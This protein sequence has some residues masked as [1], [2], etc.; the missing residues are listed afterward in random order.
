MNSMLSH[1]A[2]AIKPSPTLMVSALAKKMKSEG[3]DVINFGV[4]EPD[5]NTPDY[6]KNAAKKALDDNFT[7]YT[8]SAGIPELRE[9]IVEKFLK[10]NN[11]KYSI[12]EILVSPGAKASIIHILLAICD[13]RDE[14]LIPSPYW[15]SYTSQVEMVD[16]HP[17]LLP[18]NMSTNFKITAHQLED[19]LSSLSSPKA[20]I[21]NSPNNPTGTVYN[22]QE[23]KEIA[24]VCLKHN[25]LILSDEIYEKLTYDGEEHHSIA[26]V[27]KKVQDITIV[28]NG[29]S[30]SYA[31]TGWRLGYAAGPHEII[32]Y[33]SRIQ[34][35]TTS[36]VNSMTQKAAVVAL[37]QND[38]SIDR[39]R[40]QFEKRR[41]FLVAELNNIPNIKCTLPKGAFYAM[42]NVSF[43]LQNNTKDIRTSADLCSYLIQNFYVAVVPGVAFGA[44]NYV[45]FSYANSMD[46][47]E[48][49]LQRFEEG[50]KSIL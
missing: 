1:R 40:Q 12:D 39:M 27:S 15:V 16:G 45:R 11:L 13:P 35:H 44:N 37:T 9:V 41:N 21:L 29:V 26:S 25:I 19:A 33:A 47:I 6:I 49:G 8:E 42:P 43:Y 34:S 20:L 50:L 3:Y 17:I 14:V 36:N 48:K 7:R 24:E 31:M 2:R 23:L 38:G 5:F 46:N 28:V 30:K 10:D 32:K 4:G 22:K 18:T